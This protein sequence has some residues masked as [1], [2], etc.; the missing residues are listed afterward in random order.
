LRNRLEG[1][2]VGVAQPVHAIRVAHRV[3]SDLSAR[4]ARMCV[5]L[6]YARVSTAER[7]ADLQTTS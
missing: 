1:R 6:G 2:A 5:L 7:N 4:F 3:L